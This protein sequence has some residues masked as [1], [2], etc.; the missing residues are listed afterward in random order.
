EET[1]H[2]A[3]LTGAR[4]AILKERSPSCGTACTW[5][6]DPASGEPRLVEGQ[7][8]TARLLRESGIEIFSEEP[9]PLPG[10]DATG[11]TNDEG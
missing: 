6:V 2:L 3:R 1:L 7:G 8:V 9:L 5:Q 4:R 11:S 10:G